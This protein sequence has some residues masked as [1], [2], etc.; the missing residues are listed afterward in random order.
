M[1]IRLKSDNVFKSFRF[2]IVLCSLLAMLYTLLTEAGIA[3]IIYLIYNSLRGDKGGQPGIGNTM[4]TDD[5][6]QLNS[7]FHPNGTDKLQSGAYMDKGFIIGLAA[8][9]ITV[10]IILFI[11]IF[12]L[13][14]AKFSAYL[15]EI[16]A[17]I[18]RIST[19]DFDAKLDIRS[20]DE[21]GTIADRLNKMADEIKQ[22]MAD[23]RN[24]ENTKNELITSV[25]HDLRTPLT[26]IL[27]YLDLAS[28]NELDA[29]TRQRYISIAYS[30]SKRLEKLIEDLFSFTKL[31]SGEL[32][33]NLQSF[34]LVK[35]VEQL[36]DEFYPSFQDN[37]LECDFET[38]EHSL[39][40]HADGDQLARA[41]ANL[42]G[43]AVKYGSAGKNIVI[44]LERKEDMAV[45][46]VINF[47]ELIPD[48]DMAYIFNRFYRVDNSRSSET[49]GSGLGLAIAK[50]VIE[51]HHGTIGVKS[52][53]GGTVFTV[54]LPIET[55]E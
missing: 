5:K 30:K 48:K 47:G 16:T 7:Q 23:E 38:K 54:S 22:L 52:D 17:G 46:S 27:G 14:T 34:D 35:L 55:Q 24:T 26:S 10:G 45:I 20:D 12:L 3:G 49:G 36:L 21:L 29:P 39:I 42:I 13:L 11:A 1:D 41:F 53:F 33:L 6:S 9:L 8:V 25:A 40:I 50:S 15:S 19:G 31:S 43:N 32:K 4:P 44:R 2:E 18:D 37:H 51:S 28:A